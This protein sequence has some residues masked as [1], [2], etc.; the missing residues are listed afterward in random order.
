MSTP[1][2]GA[3]FPPARDWDILVIGG[4]ITGAGILLE[5]VRRG[6]KVLLVEQADFG[7]GTSSRSSKLMHG[8][9]RYLAAG[10][11]RRTRDAVQE[12][13]ALLRAAPGLVEAQDFAFANHGADL[14]RRLGLLSMLRVVDLLTGRREPQW[15][16]LAA[17][18]TPAPDAPDPRHAGSVRYTDAKTDDARLVLRVLDEARAHGAVA[19]NYVTVQSLVRDGGKVHGALLRDERSKRETAVRARV[20]IDAT[21]APPPASVDPTRATPAPRLRW[22]RGSHLVLPAERL[23]LTQAVSLLHPL[24]GRPVFAF[25]WEGVTLVGT[26]DVDQ[27][28]EVNAQARITRAE[29]DYLMAA[30]QA[31]FA[32]HA[33]VDADVLATFAGVR[34]VFDSGSDGVSISDK[35]EHLV[36]SEPGLVSVAGGTLTTFRLAARDVLREAAHQL[37]GWQF[38]TER[39]SVFARAVAPARRDLAPPVLRRLT[40]RHGAHVKALLMA[41]HAGELECIPGTHTLWAE[42]RWAARAE[43]VYQLDDLLLRRT[44]LGILLQDGAAALFGRVRAICQKELGWDDAQWEAQEKRYLAAWRAQHALPPAA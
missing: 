35:R 8:G 4:G 30:L 23:P 2:S 41:A 26:T 19:C 10:S 18:R 42:L 11:L 36:W 31:Q 15:K 24:D 5:A 13:E 17:V 32:Q 1:A 33:L 29:C 25:P 9:L 27:A 34:L 37:P 6:L 43:Q 22:L 40:G 44:R 20:V 14:T 38:R 39:G 7:C 21:G 16:R 12:R 3:S 28:A